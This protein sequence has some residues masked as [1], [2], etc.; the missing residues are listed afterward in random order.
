MELEKAIKICKTLLTVKHEIYF[1]LTDKVAIETVLQELEKR[2]NKIQELEEKNM[3]KDLEIIGVEE[4]TKANMKEIIEHYYTANEDCIPKRKIYDKIEE[5]KTNKTIPI[6]THGL[7]EQEEIFGDVLK[8]L[9]E[10][11]E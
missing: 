6:H 11:L 7:T 5:L 8:H 3:Q 9:Q 1:T 4:Y 10:L 2:N